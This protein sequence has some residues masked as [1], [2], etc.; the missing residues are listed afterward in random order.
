MD[1]LGYGMAPDTFGFYVNSP[2]FSLSEGPATHRTEVVASYPGNDVLASGLLKG[3][4]LMAGRAAVVAVDMNPGRVVLF[5]L[6]PQHRA[7][8]HATFPMLFNALYLSAAA[9]TP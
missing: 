4:E 5:G 1:P 8:T 6:R 3:E 2:F 7:Q 9:A